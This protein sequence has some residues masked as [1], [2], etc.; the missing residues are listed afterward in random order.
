[1]SLLHASCVAFGDVGVL[2]RGKSGSGKSS[3]CLRL[4]D[5]EGFGLG[6]TALCAILVADDQVV[7]SPSGSTLFAS[8][9]TALAGKLEI[10]GLGI[11][12]LP[13]Q[14]TAH[15]GMV[16]D[17]LSA[18]EIERLPE[19]AAL[20]ATVEGVTLPRL[21]LDAFDVAAAAKLRAALNHFGLV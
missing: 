8:P 18:G 3:L 19:P 13:H 6:T 10:R 11:I 20:Q 16:I 7:I 1:M 12:A 4:I 5:G 21:A 14:P 15:L 17:L 2:I 9:P